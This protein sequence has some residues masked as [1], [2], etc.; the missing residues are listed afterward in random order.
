MSLEVEFRHSQ[1]G[2]ALDVACRA[3]NGIQALFGPSGAGKS[4]VIMAVAGLLKPRQ[5]RI[6][7]NNEVLFDSAAGIHMPPRLRRIA[8]VFQ[9]GRL[10]P[11]LTVRDNL[12]YG[13]KR[14]GR[15][16]PM[17]QA[18][19]LIDLLG[20][21][22]FLD[23]RPGDLSGGER[24]R[25][26]LGRA[27]LM[28]PRLILLDEPLSALD[29]NRK[30]EILPYLE[31]L[32]D[33]AHIP[34]LYVSHA[35][36]EVVRLADRLIL[37]DQ[38]HIAAEGPVTELLSRLDLVHLTGRLEAGAVI[39]ARLA[40]QHVHDGLSELSFPGGSLLVPVLKGE[41]GQRVRLRVR[42]RD[43]IL[44]LDH[45]SGISA[46]NSLEGVVSAIREDADMTYLEVALD[47]GGTT[48]LS[49]ITRRAGKMLALEPGKRMHAVI[50]S[51]N[52]ER[53]R[54]E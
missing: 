52:L 53:G 30:Q 8:T 12:F 21:S 5:G 10:F 13:W 7:L 14:N 25:V 2:F 29:Q 4:T 36:E 33:E 31:F 51:V 19:R 44:S 23:R 11:H 40:V 34:M 32:R 26:A 28:G 43:V 42:A 41:L 49:R 35:M 39:D 46:L 50:K 6:V 38:G 48:I 17:E 20:L 27:L 22:G 16:V 18:G 54:A 3:D 24:Q 37:I 47:C 15:L 45:P 9:D 1:G